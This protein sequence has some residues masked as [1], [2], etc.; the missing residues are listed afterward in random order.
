MYGHPFL[1]GNLSQTDP[2][3]LAYYLP[4]LNLLREL[5]RKHAHQILPHL[6]DGTIII[7]IK[8]GDLIFLYDLQHSSLGPWWTGPHLVILTTLTAVKLN[9][10]PQW[11]HLSRLC[12]S[13]KL[14]P[15]S[16]PT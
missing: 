9:G 14:S 8:P 4:Y 12:L 3:S 6:S 7:S 1:L 13:C 11:Q 15:S 10:N 2:V 16:T 5:L